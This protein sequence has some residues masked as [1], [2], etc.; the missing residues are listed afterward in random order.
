MRHIFIFYRLVPRL[1]GFGVQPVS[2]DSTTS[3][4]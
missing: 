2:V 1:N 4:E 3:L